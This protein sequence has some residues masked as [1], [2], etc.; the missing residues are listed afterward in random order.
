MSGTFS[1]TILTG[2]KINRKKTGEKEIRKIFW[3][4]LKSLLNWTQN[5]IE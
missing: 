4:K 2:W 3:G 5:K 1:K